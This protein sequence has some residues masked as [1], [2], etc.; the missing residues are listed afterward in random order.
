MAKH[1]GK[2]KAKRYIDKRNWTYFVRVGLGGNQYKGFYHKPGT[3]PDGHACRNLP[4]RDTL[5]EAQSDLDALA[6]K[7]GWQPKVG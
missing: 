7:K 1:S 6:M 2:S 3:N 5:E 4:W